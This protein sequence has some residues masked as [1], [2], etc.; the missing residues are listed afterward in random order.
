MMK[1]TAKAVAAMAV[2][3]ALM[4]TMSVPAFA[5]GWQKND[6]GWWYGTNSDN[7]TWYANEW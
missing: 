4:G 7:T 2:A 5:A 1:K 6:T 3:T